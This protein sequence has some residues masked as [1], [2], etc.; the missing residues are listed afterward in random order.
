MFTLGDL[1]KISACW[2]PHY[3]KQICH[4][5]CCDSFLRNLLDIF[6][7]TDITYVLK[8]IQRTYGIVTG[9]NPISVFI[10]LT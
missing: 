8:R 2:V 1:D 4:F 7:Y 10:C 9:V 5:V 3:K 6:M